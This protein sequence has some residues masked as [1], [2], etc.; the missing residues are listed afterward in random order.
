MSKNGSTSIESYAG[1]LIP[2]KTTLATRTEVATLR[3]F[4][5]S[6]PLKQAS[7]TLNLVRGHVLN[8]AVDIQHLRR[9]VKYKEVP[10]HVRG[11]MS[12]A[13]EALA[14][15]PTG[16][17]DSELLL[18]IGSTNSVIE[19]DIVELLSGSLSTIPLCSIVVPLLAPTSQE[20]AALWT[21]QYWPT[22]YKKSNPFGPHPSLIS[23]AEEDMK[24]DAQQWIDLAT[25]AAREAQSSKCGEAVGVVIVERKDG[26]PTV[27]A[28]AGDA[29]YVDWP[30][31]GPGNVTA[32]AALRAIA[33]IADR[34]TAGD[35]APPPLSAAP[36]S[37]F[38]D[39]PL[40]EAEK[41]QY[42]PSGSGYLCHG[43]EIYCTHEPCVMC[44]M[45]ILHS[46]F[47]RVIFGQRMSRTGGLCADNDLGHGLFWRK[48]L[49]WA[50]FAWEMAS[51]ESEKTLDP[52]TNA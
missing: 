7:S 15:S 9:F 6:V 20:Q 25:G 49:N 45:A 30:H 19:K 34:L 32:H 11:F 52:W 43:L 4:I 48:E 29:R 21:S 18:I 17:P 51:A 50:L 31:D 2:L 44:S 33:M 10:D 24:G 23:R 12:A 1:K 5:T 47:G 41:A 16:D 13:K 40:L 14:C 42:P 28:V 27:L 22:V 8:D 35:E 38:R 36:S 37:L 39:A 3:V 26:V 46:R